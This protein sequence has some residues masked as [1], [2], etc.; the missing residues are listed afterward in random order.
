MTKNTKRSS[1]AD[2]EKSPS[3]DK[4]E[5]LIKDFAKGKELTTGQIGRL[6]LSYFLVR[7]DYIETSFKMPNIS[8]I[9]NPYRGRDDCPE[10]LRAVLRSARCGSWLEEQ[11]IFCTRMRDVALYILRG[12]FCSMEHLFERYE[13]MQ[14]EWQCLPTKKPIE[15]FAP[16]DHPVYFIDSKTREDAL[17]DLRSNIAYIS[18]FNLATELIAAY[19]RLPEIK[20]FAVDI[21]C[22][23]KLFVQV[24]YIERKAL[25]MRAK[26]EQAEG[27]ER[28]LLEDC[29]KNYQEYAFDLPED[30]PRYM[31]G[32]I[33]E[34]TKEEMKEKIRN[35]RVFDGNLIFTASA[36]LLQPAYDEILRE[37]NGNK[38]ELSELK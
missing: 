23:R 10:Y 11:Q 37:S 38:K 20:K 30:Y 9:M 24:Y 28:S 31:E 12:Q 5:K 36:P 1:E 33:S 34:E 26:A 8:F 21:S 14:V 15:L 27:A 13:R 16:F 2:K 32:L 22:L 25:M 3:T 7:S 19:A 6:T 18:A 4:V 35:Y 17:D 29:F